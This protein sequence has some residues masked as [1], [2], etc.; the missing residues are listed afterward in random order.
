MPKIKTH[1]AAAKR[2]SFTSTGKI[3]LKHTNLR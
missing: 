2:F 3:K 1:K